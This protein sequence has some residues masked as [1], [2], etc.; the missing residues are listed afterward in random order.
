MTFSSKNGD[1]ILEIDGVNRS[2]SVQEKLMALAH[3]G[4]PAFSGRGLTP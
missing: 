4:S 1:A 2:R 3:G